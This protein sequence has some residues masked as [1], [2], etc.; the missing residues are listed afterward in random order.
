MKVKIL[1]KVHSV[2]CTDSTRKMD[3]LAWSSE[4]QER[5]PSSIAISPK[6]KSLHQ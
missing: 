3:V 4:S 5:H 2:L 6:R 1:E